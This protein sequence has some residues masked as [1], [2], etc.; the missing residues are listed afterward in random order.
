[1]DGKIE[2]IVIDVEAL[3][4]FVDQHTRDR[5][6]SPGS[7]KQKARSQKATSLEEM[8]DWEGFSKLKK[9]AS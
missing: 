9:E 3:E 2:T 7:W 1:M 6:L 4:K 5:R 8:A